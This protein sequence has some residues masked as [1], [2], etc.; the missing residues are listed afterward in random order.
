V[1]GDD[2][3]W[4]VQFLDLTDVRSGVIRRDERFGYVELVTK[5]YRSPCFAPETAPPTGGSA[6]PSFV[7]VV[8]HGGTTEVRF[9]VP[10]RFD[11]ASGRPKEWL[12][13]RVENLE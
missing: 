11:L 9:T 3:S 8:R 7:R 12:R 10:M 2:D 13:L 5:G 6:P 1:W 4:K